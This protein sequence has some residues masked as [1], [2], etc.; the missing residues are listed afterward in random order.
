MN[1]GEFIYINLYMD[2]IIIVLSVLMW[3]SLLSF[4]FGIILSIALIHINPIL[5][6]FSALF[7][8]YARGTPVLIHVL[9]I[10]FG[11]P[12]F[13]IK[14]SPLIAGVVALTINHSAYCAEIVRGGMQTIPFDQ[15]EA[16]S[17]LGC[18]SSAVIWKILLPQAIPSSLPALTNEII[19]ILR[20][21]SI[22]SAITVVELTHVTQLAISSTFQPFLFYFIL[23]SIYILLSFII[24]AIF[25][26]I[27]KRISPSYIRE[28]GTKNA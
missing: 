27:E 16:A 14:L 1:M 2:A 20:N 8:I 28:N 19:S 15:I 22:L 18:K 3:V 10:Y 21:T 25:K 13:G 5:K 7:I 26:V 23:S 9:L 6:R 4:I 11:F 12:Q 24:Q 17:D